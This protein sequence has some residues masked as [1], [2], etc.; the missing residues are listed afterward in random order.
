[1][2]LWTEGR[3]TTRQRTSDFSGLLQRL[4]GEGDW[5]PGSDLLI[6]LRGQGLHLATTFEGDPARAAT[7]VIDYEPMSPAEATVAQPPLVT[8][9]EERRTGGEEALVYRI[10]FRRL[11]G[12]AGEGLRYELEGSTTMEA[13][14]WRVLGPEEGWMPVDLPILDGAWQFA[15][16]ERVG[17]LDEPRFFTRFQVSMEP[18]AAE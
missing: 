8:V 11:S 15:A 5:E 9:R 18:D 7:L 14:S 1:M 2:A 10:L 6:R 16:Y 13:N 4:T 17:P 3:R 12:V